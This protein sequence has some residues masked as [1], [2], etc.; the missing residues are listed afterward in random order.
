M[1]DS[2]NIR[3]QAPIEREWCTVYLLNALAKLERL[4]LFSF[5]LKE[6]VNQKYSY[7]LNE[8][9]ISIYIYMYLPEL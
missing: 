7:G 5:R 8:H 4:E 2:P 6:V 3:Y 1:A 9:G